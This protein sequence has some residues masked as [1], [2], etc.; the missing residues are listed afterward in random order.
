MS[1][2]L[3]KQVWLQHQDG[4]S[5]HISLLTFSQR[6]YCLASSPIK[7]GELCFYSLITSFPGQPKGLLAITWHDVKSVEYFVRYIVLRK[8]VF[9]MSL[10]GFY[11][12]QFAFILSFCWQYLYFSM[13]ACINVSL[14]QS[15]SILLWYDVLNK[16]FISYIGKGWLGEWFYLS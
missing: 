7:H 15:S 16:A 11:V 3:W 13:Y 10:R 5:V 14:C 4:K 8:C 1:A 12:C 6:Y 9:K 2:C